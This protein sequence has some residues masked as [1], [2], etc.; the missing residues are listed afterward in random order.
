MF[1]RTKLTHPGCPG[2]GK[3]TL[4]KLLSQEYGYQHISVGDL[5][6]SIRDDL[7]NEDHELQEHVRQGKLVPTTTIVNILESAI[8]SGLA[9]G[10]GV[11][12]D[13]FPRQLD[14]NTALVNEVST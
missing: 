8:S 2:S 5:L 1:L 10:R 13:G 9:S 11:I 12:L 7:T 4:C 14:Q 3:G 6:R